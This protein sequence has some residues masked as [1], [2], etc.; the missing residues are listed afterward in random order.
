M[1]ADKDKDNANTCCVIEIDAILQETM[2]TVKEMTC[3]DCGQSWVKKDGAWLQVKESS[4]KEIL[5][6]WGPPS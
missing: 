4:S 6:T 2:S 3:T 5:E 1:I